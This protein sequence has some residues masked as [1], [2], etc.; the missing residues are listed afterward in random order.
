[1]PL[2]NLTSLSNLGA[3]LDTQVSDV[4]PLRNLTHLR[5]LVL[6]E[7]RVSD[8]SPLATLTELRTLD[9][10]GT[11]VKDLSPLASLTNLERL[12]LKKTEATDEEIAKLKNKL[13][14]CMII[15]QNACPKRREASG[16][17]TPA[18]SMEAEAD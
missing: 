9:L 13:P 2:A 16:T 12:A 14:D 7:P 3:V 17:M 5:Q 15:R 6:L 11:Q 10:C 1:M 8:V 4:S 18:R